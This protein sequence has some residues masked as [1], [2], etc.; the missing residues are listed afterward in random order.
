MN[1][2]RLFLASVLITWW[3]GPVQAAEQYRF[4]V[5]EGLT[6]LGDEVLPKGIE[7][8][9]GQPLMMVIGIEGTHWRWILNGCMAKK[10][11]EFGI[12]TTGGGGGSGDPDEDPA[13]SRQ[14]YDLGLMRIDASLFRLRCLRKSCLIRHGSFG[15]KDLESL[16]LL[17]GESVELPIDRVIDVKFS[18]D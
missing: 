6:A 18:D 4:R 2:R 8:M 1:V 16:R 5:V 7:Q 13:A 15:A 17:Q 3:A 11:C 12:N 9:R 14:M 10:H